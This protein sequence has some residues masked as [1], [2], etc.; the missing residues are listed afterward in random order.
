M[1]EISIATESLIDS[2]WVSLLTSYTSILM[3]VSAMR[4]ANSS[5][6]LTPTPP[7]SLAKSFVN[8]IVRGLLSVISSRAAPPPFFGSGFAAGAGAFFAAAALG[9]MGAALSGGLGSS[10][11]IWRTVQSFKKPESCFTKSAEEVSVRF[12]KSYFSLK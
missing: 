4:L 7:I 11:S 6:I 3:Y 12:R 1:H 10:P 5:L 9:S 2:S 8:V